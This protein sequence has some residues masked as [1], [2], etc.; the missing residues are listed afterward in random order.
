M[1]ISIFPIP[2]AA[3]GLSVGRFP[4]A[5]GNTFNIPAGLTLQN[6]LT[7][8]TSFSTGQLPAQVWV[9]MM[10][11]GGSGG[12]SGTA[13]G[14]QTSGGGGGGGSC[15]GWVDVP[16]AGITA[17]IGAG[18]TGVTGTA[19]GNQGGNTVFG[20]AIAYGGGAGVG[21][22]TFWFDSE[23]VLARGPRAGHGG[24]SE[25]T[26]IIANRAY[27]VTGTSAPFLGMGSVFVNNSGTSAVTTALL[28][29]LNGS[30][31]HFDYNG[32]GSNLG[33]WGSLG[34]DGLAGGGGSGWSANAGG[35][36][37]RNQG[38]S[39]TFT[40]GAGSSGGAG[41]GG[42]AGLLANGGTTANNTGGA[43]GSGGGGGGGGYS[44]QSSG[45]GGA[46]CVLI[47]Y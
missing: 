20:N 37:S 45:A 32:G 23:K 33:P 27:Q 21:G 16:S 44:N 35:N 47:Y 3:S 7:S 15:I 12:T 31:A 26:T 5:P 34:G 8:T 2:T 10:G 9:V 22:S 29:R 38:I 6:T 14:N 46:G 39:N 36:S 4:A 24:F 30:R 1:G 11:G 42:G 25:I 19:T 13:D 40:G 41:G 17:T 18:G 43:G 28:S